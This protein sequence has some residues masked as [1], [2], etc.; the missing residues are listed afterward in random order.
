M[1]RHLVGVLALILVAAGLAALWGAG[2]EATRQNLGAGCLR[3]GA[4]LA[5]LW[6]A[7]PDVARPGSRWVVLGLVIA[8]FILTKYPKLIVLV[9]AFLAALALLRPRLRTYLARR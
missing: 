9:L 1:Q 5:V 2:N 3:V 6:L 7:L 4:V 8:V